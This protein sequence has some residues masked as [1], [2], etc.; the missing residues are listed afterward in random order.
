MV[1]VGMII[2]VVHTVTVIVDMDRLD[3]QDIEPKTQIGSNHMHQSK[4]KNAPLVLENVDLLIGK[5][6]HHLSKDEHHLKDGLD[7]STDRYTVNAIDFQAVAVMET[8]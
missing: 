4:I 1:I 2:T 5:D 7:H 8:F 6:E 3:K